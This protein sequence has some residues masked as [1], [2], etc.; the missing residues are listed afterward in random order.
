MFDTIIR[1]SLNN[2]LVVAL[3]SVMAVVVGLRVIA[4]TSV[5]VFPDLNRPTVTIMT[6]APGLAPEE[7]EALVTRP[8]EWMMNGA[9]GVQRVRS[10]SA[11]G[12]SIVWVEFDWGS[13]IYIDRQIV[14]ERLAMARSRMPG[15]VDPVMAPISSIM[16]EIMLLA[17][18]ST[19]PAE[20][21]KAS[22]HQAMEMRSFGEFTLRNRLLSLEGVSQV[23]VMGGILKQYQVITS[24]QKLLS[25]NVTLQELTDAASRANV[26]A[27]GGVMQR[28]P[29]E[30]VVRIQG[31]SITLEDIGSTPIQWREPIPVRIRDVADVQWGGPTRRGDGG[32]WRRID[33]DPTRP[34]EGGAAVMLAIQKQPQ[35][36]TLKLDRA[37]QELVQE[38]RSELPPGVVLDTEIFRQSRFISAAIDNVLESVTDGAIW[39]VVVLVILLGNVRTSISSL[40]SMPT[41]IL[42]T[43]VVFEFFG[44]GINTMSLGGI[45]VA[46]GDLVDDSIVDIENIYRRL[47][48]N[49]QLPSALRRDAWNV[50]YDASCEVRNSIVY[51]TA[52]VVLVIVPLF[53][54][55]GIE[56]R[57]FAPLGMSYLIA[58]SCS[59][60]VSLT[61]TPV[62]G[63]WLLPQARFLER[64]QEPWLTRGLKGLMARVLRW[65]LPRSNGILA[66]TLVA[67]V[68]S[69]GAIFGMGGEF[70]PTLHEGTLTV[71]L[72][73][74]P[75]TSLDESVRVA[76]QVEKTLFEI[77]EVMSV[78]RRTGRAELDEH[79][80]GVHS[81]EI[82]VGLIEHQVPKAEWYARVLR[83]IPILHLWSYE[84]RGRPLAEVVEDVRDRI[85]AIPGAAVNVGQPISHRIDHMM[86]GIR[87]QIAVKAFGPDLQELRRTGYELETAMGSVAGVV[88]LRMEP[89]VEISQ[90]R[91]EIRREEAA[92]HG[93]APGDIAQ[94]LETAYQG[95][96]VSQV[97]EQDRFYGLVVWYDEASRL[98]PSAVHETVI[99]TPSK[100]RLALGQLV[101]VLDTTGPNVLHRE[102]SQRRVVVSCNVH[103]RDLTS[104]VADIRTAIEPIQ[105]QLA[106]RQQGYRLQ[107][108]GLFES[109]QEANRRLF[110]LGL[111]CCVGI[112]MLLVKA[113]GSWSAALQVMVNIPLA[114]LGAVLMLLAVNRPDWDVLTA[115]PWV[116]WPSV[117]IGATT[118]SV[119]H[120]VGFITLIGI[121]SRNGIMM[122][123]HYNHLIEKEGLPFSQETIIRGSLDRLLP[124]LMT[125][126]TSFIGLT[127]LLFGAGQTG[128]E[129]L[130]P[131]AIV[132]FGGMLSSTLLDQL[133]TPALFYR[134]SASRYRNRAVVSSVAQSPMDAADGQSES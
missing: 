121:V 67:V 37:I 128:K 49:Q 26:V 103:D 68:L 78:A 76:Q 27:G 86:S 56:G 3:L 124:V 6:E 24:P 93:L 71:S 106:E 80:E 53:F 92:R 79:A 111:L 55:S 43:F 104:V 133:V 61:L 96:V 58:L 90:V 54:L 88:D 130:H 64:Q 16:G 69:M 21:L 9:T 39:V 100:R 18:R 116:Q 45:A 50:V 52:I 118:L 11:I 36:D 44:M 14:T 2:R 48:E 112:L 114:L 20:D 85:A 51:A 126:M 131:L 12:L 94:W 108:S 81:S 91:M 65:T 29:R 32:S 40:V 41:S 109:Q 33:S 28:S 113:V 4:T 107:L 119:A 25:Q 15:D 63:Y 70:L 127:P 117:W 8:I 82:D 122:I 5:D 30:S 132:V 83:W 101:D 125:A 120:W 59:L 13:D 23:S 98:D 31:Q 17:L 72:Q 34:F 77:P 74:E 47:R 97:L 60:L 75:G 10:S 110:G 73:L 115:A 35:A 1:F 123:S 57:L 99:E 134:F 22:A 87:A 105:R 66:M 102:N 38:I 129:I 95:R 62:L 46:I 42:L 19:Q 89:Q 84:T 7:V